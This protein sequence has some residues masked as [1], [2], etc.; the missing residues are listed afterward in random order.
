MHGASES[1]LRPASLTAALR[2][3]GPD[4]E[5]RQERP[6]PAQQKIVK[7]HASQPEYPQ[8]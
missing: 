8:L 7:K 5:R 3:A 4:C 1:R 2:A 6:G